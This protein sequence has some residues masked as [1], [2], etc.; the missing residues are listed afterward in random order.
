MHHQYLAVK[1]SSELIS[2]FEVS[3]D[4]R[5]RGELSASQFFEVT[6]VNVFGRSVLGEASA[7]PIVPSLLCGRL[8]LSNVK[9]E[10]VLQSPKEPAQLQGCL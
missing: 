3:A 9:P 10:S 6:E 4:L 2:L 1:A 7:L 5:G 8:G